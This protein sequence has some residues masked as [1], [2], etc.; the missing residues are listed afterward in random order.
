MASQPQTIGRNPC[1]PTSPDFLLVEDNEGDIELTR[2]AFE[3][4]GVRN[5]LHVVR[6]GVEAMA[7]LRHE[8]PYT[9]AP[10][11]DLILLDLNM[12]RKDGR[13]VLQEIKNDPVL[14]RIPVVV[15]STSREQ[16]D[17]L[18]SYDYHANSYIPKPITMTEFMSVVKKIDDYWMSVVRLPKYAV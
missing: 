17:I 12:P 9:D 18:N 8:P 16:Q 10:D 2:L 5:N 3:E 13:E 6:D 11:V 4:S 15:L 1:R 14:R 7:F